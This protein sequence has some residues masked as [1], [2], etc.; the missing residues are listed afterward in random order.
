MAPEKWVEENLG[1]CHESCGKTRYSK[2]L[3]ENDT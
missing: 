3:I 2:S 1:F